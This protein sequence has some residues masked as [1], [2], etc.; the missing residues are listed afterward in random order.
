MIQDIPKLFS[1]NFV[2]VPIGN[3]QIEWMSLTQPTA[4]QH[5]AYWPFA[6]VPIHFELTS[7]IG[8]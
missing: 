6:D 4:A 1:C 3:T 2:D 5:F 7:H 8:P